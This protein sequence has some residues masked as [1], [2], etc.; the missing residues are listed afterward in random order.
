[1]N[2]GEKRVDSDICEHDAD[3]TYS[4]KDG[5]RPTLPA[6]ADAK[7]KINR[8]DDP[9]DKGPGLLRIPGPVSTPG[10]LRPDGAGNDG[11]GEE[12][13]PEGDTAVTDQVQ[14]FTLGDMPIQESAGLYFFTQQ[15]DNGKDEGSS[16]RASVRS[17]FADG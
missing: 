5:C 8:V 16:G 10:A 12:E 7:M 3:K 4:S 17:G 11:E 1:M 2:T 15:K 9:G 6:A 13:K 14:L